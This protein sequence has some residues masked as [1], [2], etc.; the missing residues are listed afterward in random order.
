MK[1]LSKFK[2]LEEILLILLLLYNIMELLIKL[3]PDQLKPL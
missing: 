2:K 1:K 3:M